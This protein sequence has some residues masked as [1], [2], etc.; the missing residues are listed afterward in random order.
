MNFAKKANAAVAG[1]VN[2]STNAITD[3]SFDVT[4]GTKFA[5]GDIITFSTLTGTYVV[6]E[7]NTNT[8]TVDKA[9]TG[10]GND[11]AVTFH[12]GVVYKLNTGA[13]L[14]TNTEYQVQVTGVKDIAG[15][16]ADDK[17]FTFRTGTANEDLEYVSGTVADGV[18]GVAVDQ[19]LEFTFNTPLDSSTVDGTNVTVKKNGVALTN[20]TDYKVELDSNDNK[21]IVVKPVG[22][23]SE[24]AV[25]EITI[26]T[27]VKNTAA[28]GKDALD[29]AKVISFRTEQTA[30]VSPKLVSAKLLDANNN[31]IGD[32]SEKVLVT[33]N[34]PITQGTLDETDFEFGNGGVI[35]AATA[36]VSADGMSAVITLAA[37]STL[38]KGITTVNIVSVTDLE[39]NGVKVTGS[40]T[41]N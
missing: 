13:K 28:Y 4:D 6:T 9:V 2:I 41:I 8:V 11:E 30:S 37:D 21:K 12:Q 15:N 17:S 36:S 38:I 20:N 31:G 22:F 40:S 35:G 32:P 29:V 16:T 25:Y 10:L 7:I 26:G 1:A 18:T 27:S 14:D 5:V 19:A 34:A 33:F 23:L 39:S 3:D 24:D